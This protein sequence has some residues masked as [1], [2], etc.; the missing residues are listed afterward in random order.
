MGAGGLFATHYHE[1]TALAARLPALSTWTMRV[2]E[3]KNELVFLHE[4]AHGAADR[5]YGI[6]VAKLAGLPPSVVR[7][8]TEVLKRLEE[9]EATATPAR[10]ADDLP[11]FRAAA[12]RRPANAGRARTSKRARTATH[13]RQPRRA[14]PP[15][16]LGT[17]VPAQGRCCG[18]EPGGGTDIPGRD[19]SVIGKHLL[20]HLSRWV[21]LERVGAGKSGQSDQGFP[22]CPTAAACPRR[23][24]ERKGRSKRVPTFPSKERPRDDPGRTRDRPRPCS[25]NR[26]RR[27]TALLSPAGFEH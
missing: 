18:G 5:S 12:R 11:L 14:Q 6:H 2:K 24:V 4:V 22:Q 10:L 13:Q 20:D 19:A 15:R 25:R 8:A 7:R 21:D 1:L 23:I 17:G 16:G 26:S 27:S 3:W 9:G